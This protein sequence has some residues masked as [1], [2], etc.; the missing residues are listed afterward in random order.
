MKYNTAYLAGIKYLDRVLA[1]VLM[2]ILLFYLSK[3]EY[4][5]WSQFQIIPATLSSVLVLGI[6]SAFLRFYSKD[7]F[8]SSI[9]IYLISLFLSL[10]LI[11]AIIILPLVI[12]YT[13]EINI[14]LFNEESTKAFAL[15]LFILIISETI[16]D[17]FENL[18]RAKLKF[19]LI[20]LV[21]LFRVLS[22]ALIICLGFIVFNIT[23]L[24]FISL[25]SLTILISFLAYLLMLFRLDIKF[26]KIKISLVLYQLRNLL[27]FTLPLLLLGLMFPALLV[28][29][30][31]TILVTGSSADLAD[32]SLV[33]SLVSIPS[34]LSI[35]VMT[36]LYTK[37]TNLHLNKKNYEVKEFTGNFILTSCYLLC[38]LLIPLCFFFTD[39]I[40]LFAKKY[41]NIPVILIYLLSTFSFL[42]TMATS[43]Q[44]I[45]TLQGKSFFILNIVLIC[46]LICLSYVFLFYSYFNYY[47]ASMAVIIFNFI[48]S[49]VLLRYIIRFNYTDFN[50]SKYL[51]LIKYVLA[52]S[53]LF[54]I[55]KIFNFE[56][57][58]INL[59]CASL[60]SLSILYFEYR[61]NNS[62]FLGIKK[63][64]RI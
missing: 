9:E 58:I 12:S 36:V 34:F 15:L 64:F 19:G 38:F 42:T 14:F 43:F 50:F 2:P 37:M 23:F 18:F 59:S 32:F 51:I 20:I 33:Y 3:H 22:K 29:V 13:Y 47:H 28:I 40:F 6:G 25:Y 52:L 24:G 46:F 39:I 55:I 8:I 61:K 26:S 63:M 31:Q 53:F 48:Y 4:A 49:L 21:T 41:S 45:I 1:I 10:M 7:K 16:Y 56:N 54:A 60:I 62:I 11:L 35:S 44:Y 30:R 57:S 17:L 5:I 27:K